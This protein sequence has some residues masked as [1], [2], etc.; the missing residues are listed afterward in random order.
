[1]TNKELFDIVTI[2]KPLIYKNVVYF[3]RENNFIQSVNPLWRYKNKQIQY[4]NTP[5]FTW[6]TV[7]LGF[8]PLFEKEIKKCNRILKYQKYKQTKAVT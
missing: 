1:M 6:R 5:H 2:D 7:S 8:H 3:K 4:I